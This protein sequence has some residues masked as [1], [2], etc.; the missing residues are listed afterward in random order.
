ML[1][2]PYITYMPTIYKCIKLKKIIYA[3]YVRL[4]ISNPSLY[5]LLQDDYI[6]NYHVN[7]LKSP[8]FHI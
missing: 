3:K 8:L 7:K 4:L 2:E 6:P 1:T 5:P